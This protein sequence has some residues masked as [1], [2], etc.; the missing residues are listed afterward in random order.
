MKAQQVLSKTQPIKLPY[1][2]QNTKKSKN[3]SNSIKS[4]A[5]SFG[6]HMFK[7]KPLDVSKK[8]KKTFHYDYKGEDDI[9]DEIPNEDE[10]YI[11][12]SS[13][14]KTENQE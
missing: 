8:I 3:P 2:V 12:G 6:P 7:A 10:V 1:K 11:K 13:L 5:S 4:L 9:N 14:K